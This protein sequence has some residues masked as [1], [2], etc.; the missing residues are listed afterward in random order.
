MTFRQMKETIGNKVLAAS[1]FLSGTITAFAADEYAAID[2]QVQGLHDTAQRSS[3][4]F[5]ELL[6]A[7]LPLIS[8]IVVVLATYKHQ[9]EKA[10]REDGNKIYIALAISAL[11][12]AVVGVF[13]DA[14]LGIVL[15]QDAGKGLQVLSNYWTTAFGL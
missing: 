6:I 2:S 5:G 8:M 3:G 1:V 10:E 14:L 15:M 11:G 9:K 7:F 13:L 4:S 12:G